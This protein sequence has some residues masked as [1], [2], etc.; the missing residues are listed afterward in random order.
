MSPSG[1]FLRVWPGSCCVSS[2]SDARKLES[3]QLVSATR[4]LVGGFIC[5]KDYPKFLHKSMHV[6]TLG[7]RAS[8]QCHL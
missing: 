4:F 5:G 2:G 3:L 8:V 1:L 7:T 6:P